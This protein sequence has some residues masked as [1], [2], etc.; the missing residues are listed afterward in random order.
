MVH[1][2]CIRNTCFPTLLTLVNFFPFVHSLMLSKIWTAAKG[3][4]TFNTG[5]GLLTSVNSVMG[6]Q[7]RTPTKGFPTLLTFIGFLPT[8]DSLVPNKVGLTTERFPTFAA[9]VRLQSCVDS[10]MNNEVGAMTKGFS[11]LLTLI[12]FLSCVDSFMYCEVCTLTKGFPTLTTH[13]LSLCSLNSLIYCRA[14]FFRFLVTHFCECFIVLN[15][16]L[17]EVS[18]LSPHFLLLGA[19]QWPLESFL[20]LQKCFQN[21]DF[22]GNTSVLLSWKL[23]LWFFRNDIL[24]SILPQSSFHH[25]GRLHSSNLQGSS[26][27]QVLL[28]HMVFGYWLASVEWWIRG[29]ICR[30]E[31]NGSL[32]HLCTVASLQRISAQY[33]PCLI[34][35]LGLVK[36]F[37]VGSWITVNT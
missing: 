23:R 30:R 33:R 31:E 15:C 17:F 26:A 20:S 24:E 18:C 7:A 34:S 8:V 12:G 32:S 6:N 13:I 11:T 10:P 29:N 28:S 5:V 16:L 3:F 22:L 21:F 37:L 27:F 35:S 1:N 14:I 9:R 25:L 2:L 36:K 4:P 19:S